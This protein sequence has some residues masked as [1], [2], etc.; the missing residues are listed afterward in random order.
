MGVPGIG[1]VRGF[2]EGCCG[3]FSGQPADVYP[4]SGQTGG[5]GVGGP[6]GE[7]LPGGEHQ[8]QDQDHR[9]YAQ[10]NAQGVG[11][12]LFLLFGAVQ[13]GIASFQII[14]PLAGLGTGGF[15]FC[16]VFSHGEPLLSWG[17]CITIPEKCK[18][19]GR[20]FTFGSNSGSVPGTPCS[21]GGCPR[22]RTASGAG[23]VPWRWP[24]TAPGSCNL[25]GRTGR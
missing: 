21:A 13:G 7:Q 12:L 6:T 14:V 23:W 15:L 18:K 17:Y 20:K 3:V 22:R 9:Q 11:I 25:A 19:T 5:D 4:G 16:V 8:S 2:V 1:G 24:R 10:G